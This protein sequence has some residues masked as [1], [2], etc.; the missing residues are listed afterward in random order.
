MLSREPT[1]LSLLNEIQSRLTQLHEGN[2]EEYQRKIALLEDARDKELLEVESARGFAVERI[3]REYEEEKRLADKEFQVNIRFRKSWVN[4]SL[5]K[6]KEK[7]N[8][9]Q[10]LVVD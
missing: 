1:F 2:D 7:T 4:G 6:R 10:R 5:V 3:E 9:W 8:Y